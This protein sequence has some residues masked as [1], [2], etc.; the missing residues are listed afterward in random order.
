MHASAIDGGGAPEYTI[1]QAHGVYVH[2]ALDAPRRDMILR[3]NVSPLPIIK[4]VSFQ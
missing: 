4:N 2:S 3:S 1:S